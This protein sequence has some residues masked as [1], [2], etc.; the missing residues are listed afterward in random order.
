MSRIVQPSAAWMLGNSMASFGQTVIDVNSF[1]E[2]DV[3]EILQNGLARGNDTVVTDIL[4][5]PPN[6]VPESH[7]RS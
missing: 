1:I 2:R 6:I 3:A 7:E 4:D 5:S